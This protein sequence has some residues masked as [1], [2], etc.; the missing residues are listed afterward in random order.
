MNKHRMISSDNHVFEPPDLW[1]SRI[2]PKFR[3]RAPR[4]VRKDDGSDWWFCDGHFVEGTG[5]GFG[6]AQTGERFKEGGGEN[7]T[8][9]DVF[10]NIRPGGYIPEEQVKDMDIDGIDVGINYPTA[11]LQLYKERDSELLSAIFRTYND[12]LAEF[13]SAAPKRL[14]GI[15]MIN[16]D[17]VAEGVKELERCAKLGFVG[18]MITVRPPEGRR[19]SQPEYD[20]LWAAAQDLR[21]PLG[22]HLETNRIGS[23][24]GDSTHPDDY[25]MGMMSNFD[26]FVRYSIADIICAGVFE[27]YPK[28]YVGAVEYEVSWAVSFLKQMDY[29]YTQRAV[30]VTP[31]RFKGELLPSDFFRS[32]I[33]LG[34]QEDEIGIRLRDIIGVDTLTWG[35]DYP[36]H[37]STF[38]RSREIVEEI[39]ADCTEEEKAKI[40][41]GNAA[42]IYNL[43]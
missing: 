41:G 6:G 7:L 14:K 28:L 26:Y 27:K 22:L 19:Y 42:R 13:S 25:S 32:N 24:D 10:E 23:G 39:L 5:F 43:N 1:T 11:G 16:V 18:G 34:F 29:V 40:V 8:V 33:F 35:S 12:W 30:E 3:D 20:R 4:V 2:E 15:A 9:A 37:E 38:P 21:M 36:H 31:Y 17:D